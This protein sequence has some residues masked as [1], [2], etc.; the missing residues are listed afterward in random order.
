MHAES[1]AESRGPPSAVRITVST[2]ALP[3]RNRVAKFCEGFAR[4]VLRLQVE[5]QVKTP[6]HARLSI[7]RL[8]GLLHVSQKF[9]PVAINRTKEL[10]NDGDDRLVMFF[11]DSPILVRQAG[12]DCEL[13]SGSGVAKLH[14]MPGG[15]VLPAGGAFSSLI[16]PAAALSMLRE[17]EDCLGRPI[18]A[19]SPALW[20]LRT[21]L[22]R[23][24]DVPLADAPDVQQLAASHAYDLMALM[25][26]ATREAAEIAKG[27]GLAAAH[28][29]IIK[30]H[31]VENSGRELSLQSV[32]ARHGIT[33][34]YI[35]KL[36]EREGVSFTEFLRDKRVENAYRML[37]SPRFAHMNIA[38][39]AYEAG[40]ND[41]SHFNRSFR[42]RW[43]ATPSDA[44]STC[45]SAAR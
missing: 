17:K 29:R 5:P 25:L 3:E 24:P 35:Q 14:A 43:G 21:Y 6:F 28:L 20:L 32:A 41:L 15:V 1:G 7:C 34:R 19:H 13:N 44:R 30:N 12:R 16:V 40:F 42:A 37:I 26:G 33:P 36:F 38:E 4:Q 18:P 10:A 2:D 22:E 31:I 23:L 45:H 39:I 27:R 8:P 9:S 11:A